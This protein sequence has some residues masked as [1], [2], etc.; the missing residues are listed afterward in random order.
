[1]EKVFSEIK[2]RNQWEIRTK[3]AYFDTNTIQG[4][5]DGEKEVLFIS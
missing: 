5:R 3:A 2:F 4:E 1:M